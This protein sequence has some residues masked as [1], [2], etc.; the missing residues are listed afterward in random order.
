MWR[1]IFTWIISTAVSLAAS[2]DSTVGTWATQIAGKDHGIC[3]LTFSNDMTVAGYGI[4]LDALGPLQL[5]GNWNLDGHGRLAGGS[6]NSS[7]VAA[8]RRHSAGT[9]WGTR[10]YLDMDRLRKPRRRCVKIFPSSHGGREG[11]QRLRSRAPTESAKIFL[12]YH[13]C[14][15]P[16]LATMVSGWMN[17]PSPGW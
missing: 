4:S 1:L 13:V 10:R 5:S 7:R 17:R 2:S 14:G 8:R 6:G 15:S 16:V 3:Y 9:K 12:C 11:S